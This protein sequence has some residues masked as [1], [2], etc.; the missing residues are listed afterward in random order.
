MVEK[1]RG[2]ARARLRQRRVPARRDRAPARRPTPPS[3][4][5]S[6]TASSTSRRTRSGCSG[7][8]PGAEA[9]RPG[10]DLRH[11]ARRE[12]SRRDRRARWRP[13][14]AASR[15]RSAR[16]IISGSWRRRAS[17]TCRSSRK[18]GSRGWSG[19]EDGSAKRSAASPSS[20][21]SRRRRP[22]PLPLLDGHFAAAHD[23][24]DLPVEERQE[25]LPRRCRTATLRGRRSRRAP[26]TPSAPGP[27]AFASTS[28]ATR[29]A[30]ARER[31]SAPMRA[32]TEAC[33][34]LPRGREGGASGSRSSGRAS[35]S[36]TTVEDGRRRCPADL[37]FQPPHPPQRLL[38][39]GA[40]PGDRQRAFVGQ[41]PA[42][43]DV[44]PHGLPLP[45]RDQPPQHGQRPPARAPP[46]P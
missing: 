13:T 29:W 37:P 17:G 20:A 10:H 5:S 43:G 23:E 34:P 25:L 28:G 3:T 38:V 12:P 16:T 26:P 19:L 8:V 1:A 18:R 24:G 6:P 4:P 45:P 27:R 7:G 39:R 22:R 41:H 30:R 14:P 42:P 2:N 11:R 15:G 32:T 35:A 31:R 44:P 33:S 9:R 40:A 21:G 36:R 46:T